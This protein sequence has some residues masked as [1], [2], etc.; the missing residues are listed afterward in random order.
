MEENTNFR[1]IGDSFS[2]KKIVFD[3]VRSLSDS[4]AVSHATASIR[5][6]EDE[7]QQAIEAVSSV[8]EKKMSE[9][10]ERRAT[11][12]QK[13]FTY[14]LGI[15]SKSF[16]LLSAITGDGDLT[17]DQTVEFDSWKRGKINSA[18]TG[19]R[20][21][22]LRFNG[23]RL[24]PKDEILDLRLYGLIGPPKEQG[25]SFNTCWAFSANEAYEAAYKIVNHEDI[26]TSEQDVIDCSGVGSG[27]GTGVSFLVYLWMFDSKANLIDSATA[28]YYGRYHTCKLVRPKTNYFA[29]DADLVSPDR[30][31][32]TVPTVKEIKE[33]ICR[34]GAIAAA[35][36]AT[37]D[38]LDYK[39][40]VFQDE[41]SY[42]G[43]ANVP[44]SNHA[45]LIIGWNEKIHCWLIENSWG[46]H[47]G[48]PC[49]ETGYKGL[50]SG[51]MW[52]PYGVGNIGKKACWVLPKA[53][54]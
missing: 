2:L 6:T 43:D 14:S 15:T 35:V 41:N 26:N 40:G 36:E 29:V 11:I 46:A 23:V 13:G 25:D 38:W 32:T 53:K 20:A 44:L 50:D 21:A 30:M 3:S 27:K 49:N 31:L 47:W 12:A 4:F 10:D 42:L 24:N 5:L 1:R 19:P 9:L 52:L 48:A 18:N 33:A 16:A 51:Y 37:L 17:P 34:H 22:P 8:W 54:K 45:V 39:G 28:P 7:A